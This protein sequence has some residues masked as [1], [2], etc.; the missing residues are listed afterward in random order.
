MPTTEILQTIPTLRLDDGKH[1][2]CLSPSRV[3]F[4]IP[5]VDGGLHLSHA[6]AV[7][8]E[9]AKARFMRGALIAMELEQSPGQAE[10]CEL[11][12]LARGVEVLDSLSEL[13]DVGPPL[14]N[15]LTGED[16]EE[17]E[18]KAWAD[19]VSL[20]ERLVAARSAD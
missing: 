2:Y 11:A 3:L 12:L 7:D 15:V 17:A 16:L 19:V 6:Q 14:V 13:D 10:R 18:P 1:A 20:A 9:S 8:M 5:L 4:R